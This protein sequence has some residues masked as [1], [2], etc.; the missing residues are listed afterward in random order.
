MKR[1][2]LNG[3][4]LIELIIIIFILGLIIPLVFFSLSNSRSQGNDAKRIADIAQLQIALQSYYDAEDNYPPELIPGEPLIGSSTK[5]IFLNKIPENYPY[6]KD[7]CLLYKKYNYEYNKEK[8]TYQISFCLESNIDEYSPGPKCANSAGILNSSCLL[9]CSNFYHIC[10]DLCSYNDYNYR[11]VKIG[12]QCWF[13]D[14]LNTIKYKDG[15]TN[16]PYNHSTWASAGT[17]PA[18]SWPSNGSIV[19]DESQGEVYGK[20]YNWYAVNTNNLCPE[21]WR[22]PSDTST[23]QGD[24][25]DLVNYLGGVSLAGG[26]M[27][28]TSTVP[29]IH[30]RWDSPNIGATNEY[31]FNALPAGIRRNTGA[32]AYLGARFYIWS[33]TNS[34]VN[35]AW[36]R[37]INSGDDNI[38]RTVYTKTYGWSVR[39]LKN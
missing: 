18:W 21:G 24:I 25:F 27:K 26:K 3:F 23:T 36:M 31:G 7:D 17:N 6:S 39:C 8:K 1:I 20:V 28:S 22:V 13:V 30:P 33:S 15:V 19:F 9:S 14:N 2:N 11:T 35:N 37:Y 29:D 10:G 12:N 32:F 34:D 4:T 5:I 16:I 38:N